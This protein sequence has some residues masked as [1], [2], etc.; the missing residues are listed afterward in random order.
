M[1]G[2]IEDETTADEPRPFRHPVA[3]A[4][5]L[6]ERPRVI[7]HGLMWKAHPPLTM[8]LAVLVLLGASIGPLY[9]LATGRLI[10]SAAAGRSVVTPLV[11]IAVL[12]A[13]QQTLG[14]AREAVAGILTRRVDDQVRSR[15]MRAM[16][17]PHGVAHLED[18]SLQDDLGLARGIAW[19][20]T[21]G[22]TVQGLSMLWLAR[23]SALGSLWLVARFRW[24]I[25]ALLLIAS[26][27]TLQSKKKSFINLT[28]MYSKG[29]EKLRKSGYFRDVALGAGA[30]KE[31]RVFGLGPWAVQRFDSAWLETMVEVWRERKRGG[32]VVLGGLA[33]KG[34]TTVIAFLY[35][36]RAGLNGELPL[37]SFVVVMQAL[38]GTASLS[39]VLGNPE[40]MLEQGS[41]AIRPAME[42]ERTIAAHDAS[43]IRG[44]RSAEG[45]PRDAIRFESVAFGYPGRDE[46]LFEDLTLE[47]PAGQSLAIVGDNGAGKTTIVKLLARLYEP[48]AGRI[49]VDGIPLT[50]IDPEAWHGRLS[51]IFQDFGRYALTAE[52][53][54]GLS[55]FGEDIDRATLDRVAERVGIR[56]LVEGWEHGWDSIL[57]RQFDK[58]VEVSGGEW[59]RVALARALFAVEKGAQVLVLDEPTAQLDVRSEAE[60]YDRFLEL[61]RGLTAMVISHRFSTVR[62]ADR[63]V[64]IEHGKVCE[65][66]S[67]AELVAMGGKY[68]E[69][70]NLQAARFT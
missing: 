28:M 14:P 29:A 38:I 20:M 5:G 48:T 34:I 43:Q 35:A 54:V 15:M 4:R 59:Q 22:Y 21:P 50:E 7:A 33:L 56:D 66:G 31:T 32:A 24:W 11:T 16:L 8:V 46:L 61:T 69:M 30:A 68:A 63:I 10:G 58:G 64:V 55:C 52:E 49:T 18:P 40:L 62:R 45:L 51:A 23:L 17:T 42:V 60:L 27:V 37:E 70:F 26:L 41:A 6:P 36:A 2:V 13:L 19:G 12:Y 1:A 53:N 65:V 44:T 25:A 3:W 47:I 39:M 57:N 9:A 67:H